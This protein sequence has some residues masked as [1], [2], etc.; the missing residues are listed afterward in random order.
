MLH[1]FSSVGIIQR[2]SF[3]FKIMQEGI[4]GASSLYL[5][6]IKENTNNCI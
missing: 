3:Y 4:K 2:Y 5:L 6:G 1:F